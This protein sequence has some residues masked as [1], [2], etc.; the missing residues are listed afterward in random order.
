M[1]ESVRG[2]GVGESNGGT[3]KLGRK[4]GSGNQP[5]LSMYESNTKLIYLKL[6]R[7]KY[8]LT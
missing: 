6:R 7:K 5:K 8:I 3:G 4:V 1:S 2:T